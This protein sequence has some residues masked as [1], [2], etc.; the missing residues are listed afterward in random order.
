VNIIFCPV[1]TP[2][3]FHDSYDK[4]NH[5]RFTKDN[6]RYQVAAYNYNDYKIEEG[7]YDYLIKDKGYKWEMAK[8]FLE[9]FDYMDYEYIGFWDDDLV[10]DIQSINRGLEIASKNEIKIWQLSTIHGSDSTHK[11]LH[12]EDML[13]YSL[14]NFNEGMGLFLHYSLIPKLLQ[15]YEIH[16]PKSGYGLDLILSSIMKTECGVIH[17]CSMFH[18]AKPSHYDK[19]QAMYEMNLILGKIYPEYM[20]KVW[21]ENVGPYQDNKKLYEITLKD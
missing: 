12:Q 2:I 8:H 10:T 13:S 5:W 17:E 14:T 18:P 9:T 1:G 4:E 21:N 16:E 15:F 7:T 3:A 11:I 19:Q 6:R 20:K